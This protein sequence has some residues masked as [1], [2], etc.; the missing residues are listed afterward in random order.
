MDQ[1]ILVNPRVEDGKSLI[2]LLTRDQFDV[3]VATWL[4]TSEEG[5]WYLYIGSGSLGSMSLADAYREVFSALRKVPKNSI[6][7]SQINLVPPD[8]AIAEAA[9]QIRNSVSRT[10]IRYRG[11]TLGGI[12]IDDAYIYP[13]SS[14][15]L[16]AEVLQTVA[17]LMNRTGVLAPSLITLR[18]GSQI[19]A[20]PVGIQMNT[21][22]EV[23]I[24]L[25]D[26]DAGT[27]RSVSA[28]DVTGIL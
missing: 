15:I 16:S 4:K 10:A 12:P 8:D 14:V 24:V 17:G 23:Q 26:L 5:L 19:Q 21:P 18:D 2:A 11:T 27:Q 13:R 9:S 3:S 28:N 6:E 20:V 22:G 1:E 7:F 25:R